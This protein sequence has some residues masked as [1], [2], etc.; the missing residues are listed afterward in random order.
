MTVRLYRKSHLVGPSGITGVS[1]ATLYRWIA[2]GKFPRPIHI[3]KRVSAWLSDDVD[4]W[5]EA[6][7]YHTHL[8][9]TSAPPISSVW[10]LG[11]NAK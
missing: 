4:A 6:H 2:A 1:A 3:G 5:I 9:L 10:A 8:D 11:A 7:R